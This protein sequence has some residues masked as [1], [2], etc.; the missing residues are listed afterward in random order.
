MIAH[1]V[2]VHAG[3][4]GPNSVWYLFWSGIAANWTRS[5]VVITAVALYSHNH[6]YRTR[7]ERHARRARRRGN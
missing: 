2:W 3:L 7:G 1:W 5:G 4:A 6:H